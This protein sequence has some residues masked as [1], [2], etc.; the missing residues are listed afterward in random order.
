MNRYLYKIYRSL[1]RRRITVCLF[2]PLSG[3]YYLHFIVRKCLY[4]SGVRK[5]QSLPCQVI[6]IGNITWG[7]TGKSPLVEFLGE[8]LKTKRIAV[9][10][11]G[12]GRRGKK[13]NIVLVSDGIEILAGPEEGGDEP[14]LLAKKLEKIPV[15]VGNNRFQSGKWTINKFKPEIIILDDGFQYL[16]L[17]RNVDIVVVDSTNPFGNRWLIP[18]GILREPITELKRAQI[19]FLSKVNETEMPPEELKKEIRKYNSL[20]PIVETVFEAVEFKTW[21]KGEVKVRE[22]IEKKSVFMLASV[23]SPNSFRYSLLQ[24]GAILVGEATYPD[25]YHYQARDIR[26]V[27][28]SAKIKKAE[29]IVTTEKDEVRLPKVFMNFPV[30]VLKVK[31]KIVKGEETLDAWLS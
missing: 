24:L 5:S 6:S 13:E 20:A 7:G 16:A 8:K 12:Y 21:P 4:K 10:S 9:L 27:I 17:K 18:A 19:I 25:H 3:I 28:N 2:W 23:G 26:R 11:R 14:Y 1:L 29:F 31:L 30:L 22:F 15:I